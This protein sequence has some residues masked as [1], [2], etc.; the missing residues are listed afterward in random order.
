MVLEKREWV[1]ISIITFIFGIIIGNYAF[2]SSNNNLINIE[3][4]EPKIY[5]DI[6]GEVKFPGVYEM[7]NGDRVFHLIEKAGG[8]TENADISSINLSKK[9][10]DGE[11]III[12]A[13][14]NL[15]DSE[16]TSSSTTQS[17]TSSSVNSPTKKSNLININTASQKELEELS[18]IGP[19]LAQRIIDYREKNG[20]FSTIEDI[21]KVS[22]IGDKRFEAI[23]DS[24]TV[25][26]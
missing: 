23:K 21:K 16:T 8:A 10:T 12:F 9:L 17:N 5:V 7:E 19:V 24:I 4:Q 1:I 15:V 26:P 6:A 25:G 14:R 3:D 11:K 22:G 2:K 18:G 20:Y 13:K